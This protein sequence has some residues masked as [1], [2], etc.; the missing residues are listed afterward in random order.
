MFTDR[1][2]ISNSGTVKPNPVKPPNKKPM[3]AFV[4]VS[5]FFIFISGLMVGVTIFIIAYTLSQDRPTVLNKA[6][7]VTACKTHYG[8]DTLTTLGDVICKDGVRPKLSTLNNDEVYS[9]RKQIESKTILNYTFVDWTA[10]VE[11]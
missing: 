9:F 5:E 10:E 4:K 11:H 1:D 7:A 8:V 6:I 3:N 2:R